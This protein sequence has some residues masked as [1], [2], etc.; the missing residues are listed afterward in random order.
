MCYVNYCIRICILPVN[1]GFKMLR[2]GMSKGLGGEKVAERSR[3]KLND[4]T[5]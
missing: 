2:P 4:N 1:E 3:E 5:F